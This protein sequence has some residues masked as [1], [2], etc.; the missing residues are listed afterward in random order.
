LDQ[1]FRRT[2]TIAPFKVDVGALGAICYK[3]AGQFGETPALTLAIDLDHRLVTVKD[4]EELGQADDLPAAVSTFRLDLSSNTEGRKISI[5]AFKDA[6]ARVTVTAPTES[7]C[8]GSFELITS[9]LDRYRPW[10]WWLRMDLV[11]LV[12]ITGILF[13]LGYVIE[14]RSYTLE[15]WSAA[16]LAVLCVV[17]SV[18]RDAV[19]PMALLELRPTATFAQ[20]YNVTLLLAALSLLVAVI[21]LVLGF[22]K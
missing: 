20:R 19:M 1:T 13:L 17:L 22:Y 12:V 4:F 9:S 3:A 10:W 5:E 18:K 8:V 6:E 2:R 11:G 7:W 16:V 14:N 21:Q 15:A